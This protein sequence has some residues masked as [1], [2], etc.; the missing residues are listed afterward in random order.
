MREGVRERDREHQGGSDGEKKGAREE[1]K[2]TSIMRR[3][4]KE[5]I[6]RARGKREREK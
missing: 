1:T 5:S 3:R 6:R 4:W 2:E